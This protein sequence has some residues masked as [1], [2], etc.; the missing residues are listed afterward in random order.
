MSCSVGEA[1]AAG[2]QV[3]AAEVTA[4]RFRVA[5]PATWIILLGGLAALSFVAMIPLMLMA[6]QLFNGLVALVIGVPCAVVG[7]LVARRQPRNPIGWLFRALA[8][9]ITGEQGARKPA[10]PVREETDGKGPGQ[11]HLAG[12]RLHAG[13]CGNGPVVIPVPRRRSTSP[14]CGRR[15]TRP[16][17]R[18]VW[19]AGWRV[20]G[21]RSVIPESMLDGREKNDS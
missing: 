17:R 14:R 2:G 3:P 6:H 11:G 20:A 9:M 21:S 16:W 19:S 4:R 18:R 12:G 15:M 10:S 8:E 13:T 1:Q 7:V 5:S